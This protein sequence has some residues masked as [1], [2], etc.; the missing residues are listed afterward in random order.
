MRCSRART[1]VWLNSEEP[2]P[3]DLQAHLGRCPD[4]QR[5]AERAYRIRSLVALKGYEQPRPG[6]EEAMVLRVRRSLEERSPA[7]DAAPAWGWQPALRYAAAAALVVLLV[8]NVFTVPMLSPLAPLSTD[9]PQPA[10][11]LV[12]STNTSGLFPS[13]WNATG[14]LHRSQPTLPAS[15]VRLVDW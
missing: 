3:P 6:L 12:A 14:T 13:E 10:R 1:L 9:L 5:F 11:L 8:L 4:C 2:P 7:I 15:G